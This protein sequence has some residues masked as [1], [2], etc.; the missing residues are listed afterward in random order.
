[1]DLD[2]EK[3]V[4]VDLLQ[5]QDPTPYLT[6]DIKD[7]KQ[8]VYDPIL[9][10]IFN[11][12]SK[13]Y[14]STSANYVFLCGTLSRL[15]YM[16]QEFEKITNNLDIVF[17]DDMSATYGAVYQA[18]SE[19]LANPRTAPICIQEASRVLE[20]KKC[21]D[22][23]NY[24]YTHIIGIGKNAYHIAVETVLTIICNRLWYKLFKVVL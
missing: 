17:Y 22:L 12:T 15:P 24:G 13:L 18:L 3:V 5:S 9:T 10:E 4:Y 6:L 14:N 19:K 2:D 23:S 1:M 7:I 20:D 21:H 8:Q 16:A 11:A